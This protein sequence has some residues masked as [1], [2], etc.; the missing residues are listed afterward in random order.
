MYCREVQG[1]ARVY[2]PQ[3]DV[4]QV[5][6]IDSYFHMSPVSFQSPLKEASEG[7][8]EALALCTPPPPP[9]S[10]SLPCEVLCVASHSLSM[11]VAPMKH[12]DGSTPGTEY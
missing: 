10:K 9:E 4:S 11:E 8:K 7:L 1:A 3:N 12:P 6:L 5:T 2:W